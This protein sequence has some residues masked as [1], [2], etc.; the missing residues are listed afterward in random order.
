MNAHEFKANRQAL[1]MSQR[2]LATAL[3]LPPVNGDRTIRRWE[4]GERDI[5]GPVQ[6]LMRIFIDDP[7][8][9]GY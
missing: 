5:P 4:A 6:K 8:L 3:N 7:D 1:G 9:A 2:Q